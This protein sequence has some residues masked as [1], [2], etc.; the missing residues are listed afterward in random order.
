M[1]GGVA[2]KPLYSGGEAVAPQPG[3]LGASGRPA[4]ERQV[5][6]GPGR[7]FSAKVFV[8][9]PL[10]D[11]LSGSGAAGPQAARQQGDRLPHPYIRVGWSPTPHLHD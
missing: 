7:K 11:R 10:E 2:A 6:Q 4:T 9:K 1:R 8:E 3:G 5:L